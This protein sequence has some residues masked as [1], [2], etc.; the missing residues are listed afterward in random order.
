MLFVRYNFRHIER[1]HT[2]LRTHF[3]NL[4][5]VRVLLTTQQMAQCQIFIAQTA[6]VHHLLSEIHISY[7]YT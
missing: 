4:S 7:S 1:N 3:H 6:L 5:L 2:T